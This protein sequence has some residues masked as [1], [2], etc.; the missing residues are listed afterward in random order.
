[1]TELGSALSNSPLSYLNFIES[2]VDVTR[3]LLFEHPDTLRLGGTDFPHLVCS[4]WLGK[5]YILRL[6]Q[7]FHVDS[8]AKASWC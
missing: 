8:A 5:R 1:L 6:K 2:F 3:F 7:S 4:F